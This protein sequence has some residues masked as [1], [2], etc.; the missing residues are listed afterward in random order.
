MTRRGVKGMAKTDMV[1]SK[2]GAICAVS[3]RQNHSTMQFQ[4]MQALHRRHVSKEADE[5]KIWRKNRL[6]YQ[7]RKLP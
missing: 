6:A 3:V 4:S 2:T 5:R 1:I 7:D